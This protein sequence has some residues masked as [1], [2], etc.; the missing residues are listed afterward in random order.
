MKMAKASKGDMAKVQGL[1][2]HFD[3]GN[4]PAQLVGA[5]NRVLYGYQMLLENCCDPEADTLEWKPEI[6]S[7]QAEIAALRERLRVLEDACL[8]S[9]GN[10][11]CINGCR[12]CD[13]LAEFLKGEAKGG[14]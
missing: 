12:N 10:C 11:S 13:R 14:G 6:A 7:L 8:L 3:T 5:L 9:I 1:I 4:G 2:D